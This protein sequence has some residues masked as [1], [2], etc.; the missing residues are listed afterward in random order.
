MNDDEMRGGVPENRVADARAALVADLAQRARDARPRAGRT[1]VVAIDGPA[2]AGKS[3]LA[4]QLA[5][6]LD[7]PVVH[8]DD[9]F[10]GWD[11][12]AVAASAVAD[13]VLKPLAAGEPAR[14]RRWDWTEDR[15]A[16]WADVPDAPI[17]IIEGCGSG[18]TPGA[19]YL[20]LLVWVDAPHDL[21][22]ARGIERDGEAFRPHWERWARQENALF[23][24]ERT[25]ERAD[26]RLDTGQ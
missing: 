19:P 21:R 25:R 17:L 16:D 11:G 4:A 26:V 6:A 5:A 3:T 2:G 1:T 13:Q 12:L 18:S 14:Y 10:P 9:I 15:Y 23:A 20:S 24:A 8:M 22:M 7:A